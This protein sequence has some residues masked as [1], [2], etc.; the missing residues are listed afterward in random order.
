MILQICRR[1]PLLF[2]DGHPY[3]L[4]ATLDFFADKITT[5]YRQNFSL[6]F[7]FLAL[8]GKLKP[9]GNIGIKPKGKWEHTETTS[10]T[11]ADILV[12]SDNE[13]S[14]LTVEIYKNGRLLDMKQGNSW[15]HLKVSL[16]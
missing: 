15:V 13:T 10:D 12:T 14:L 5:F 4:P 8:V 16:K 11:F 1:I 9:I 2:A 6:S 3:I 7:P